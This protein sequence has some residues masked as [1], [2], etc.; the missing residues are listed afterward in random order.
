[1]A[2][3]TRPR[4]RIT[5]R[6]RCVDSIVLAVRQALPAPMHTRSFPP[7]G[8]R[9]GPLEYRVLYVVGRISMHRAAQ[10]P[11]LPHDA[12]A[13]PAGDGTNFGPGFYRLP[14]K[15]IARARPSASALC[16]SRGGDS[17]RR[18]LSETCRPRRKACCLRQI[19]PIRL[20]ALTNSARAALENSRNRVVRQ[21]ATDPESGP[22]CSKS[23]FPAR[24]L[25]GPNNSLLGSRYFPVL[26]GRTG[27]HCAEIAA[28][29][30][31]PP[32]P[33]R[34]FPDQGILVR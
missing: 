24:S 28:N 1:M 7:E 29:S 8:T 13:R 26:C 3:S 10:R 30:V 15:R 33:A 9:Y 32:P 21:C 12:A 2:G 23:P 14:G 18:P 16:L 4:S 17:H 11:G 34:N 5:E 31:P 22:S 20:R 19:G 25:F 27:R 6:I